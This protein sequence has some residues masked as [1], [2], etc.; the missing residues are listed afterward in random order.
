MMATRFISSVH[1]GM[2]FDVKIP[3]SAG[4]LVVFLINCLWRLLTVGGTTRVAYRYVLS[5]TVDTFVERT[6]IE[7][8]KCHKHLIHPGR[9]LTDSHR[10]APK[11]EQI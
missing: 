1:N 8:K 5:I 7:C 11:D 10:Q 3:R 6:L 9:H 4:N 2:E